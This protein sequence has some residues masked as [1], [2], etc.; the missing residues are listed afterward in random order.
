LSEHNGRDKA[1]AAMLE[2]QREDFR[3]SREDAAIPERRAAGEDVG[4]RTV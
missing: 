4:A 2:H 1:V 3:A